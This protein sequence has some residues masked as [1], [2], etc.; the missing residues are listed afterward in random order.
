MLSS[1]DNVIPL[2]RSPSDN[3]SLIQGAD[4]GI[5]KDLACLRELSLQLQ[6]ARRLFANSADVLNAL[7]TSAVHMNIASE[8]DR[9][10]EE[11]DALQAGTATLI[12]AMANHRPSA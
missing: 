1:I 12:G 9:F 8:T 7:C 4:V 5:A 6:A 11:I 3:R 2:L 10:L